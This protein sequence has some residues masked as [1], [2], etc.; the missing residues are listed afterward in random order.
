VHL[1]CGLCGDVRK[2]KPEKNRNRVLE[3]ENR[4]ESNGIWKIQTDP[5]LVYPVT[6]SVILEIDCNVT[7]IVQQTL[8]QNHIHTQV[9]QLYQFGESLHVTWCHATT[10]NSMRFQCYAYL[11]TE[12]LFQLLELTIW[13][14]NR[15]YIVVPLPLP[16]LHSTICCNFGSIIISNNI[17]SI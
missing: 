1:H 16:W 7:K 10:N 13:Y 2:P 4:T 5:A 9:N 8:Y 3:I 15:K 14:K 11:E 12:P 17:R 6:Y